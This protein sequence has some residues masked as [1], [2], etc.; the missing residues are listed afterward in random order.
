MKRGQDL[1]QLVAKLNNLV[2]G[3]VTFE[4]NMCN[5]DGEVMTISVDQMLLNTYA[6]YKNVHKIVLEDQ[7]NKVQTVINELH[8]ISQ[9]KTVLA[10]W[11][12]EFPDDVDSVINGIHTDTQIDTKIIKDLFDKYTIP[13]FLKTRID[14]NE[15]EVEKQ[16]LIA[17]L[18]NL[19]SYVWQ[20]YES[21]T[22]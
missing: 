9:I 12:K 14:I 1:D 4:C 2:T 5:T 18:N 19:D 6:I 3:S 7:I 21:P 13:R 16:K 20:H 17:N 15:K 11:I 22:H 8:I 10:K